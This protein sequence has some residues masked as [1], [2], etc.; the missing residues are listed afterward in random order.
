MAYTTQFESTKIITVEKL[1][2]LLSG[3]EQDLRL[4]PNQVGNLAVVSESGAY[5]G[6]LDLLEE[7]YCPNL[8]SE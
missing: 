8:D 3:L 5:L 6:Y 2:E 1:S 4:V 7:K